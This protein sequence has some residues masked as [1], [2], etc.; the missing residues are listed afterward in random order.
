MSLWLPADSELGCT[1]P[2]G[3]M[4]HDPVL[5]L[6]RDGTIVEERHYLRKP[7]DVVLLP[8][9]AAAMRRAREHGYRLV[10]LSNQS[11]IGRG[12]IEEAAFQSVQRRVDRLLRDEGG[13]LDALFYC[14][15]APDA[16]CRCRKPAPGLLEEAS[17]WLTWP[18]ARS[19][20]IGDKACD[21]QLGLAGGMGAVLVLT[22]HGVAQQQL[23]DPAARAYVAGDLAGA[24]AHV[25]AGEGS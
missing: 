4:G 20:V 24:V 5:F 2:R 25:L 10:G 14:P 9:A 21:V 23:L 19:W 15:H 1:R 16:G 6:D 18:L 7:A 11:G 22:G 17:A 13:Q 8:R 3:L 12:I